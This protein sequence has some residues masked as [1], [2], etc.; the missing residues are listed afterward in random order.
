[1]RSHAI[2]S[3]AAQHFANPSAFPFSAFSIVMYVCRM[4]RFLYSL[5]IL[6]LPAAD[7]AEDDGDGGGDAEGEF[8]ACSTN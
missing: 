3:S 1:M 5:F 7:G 2:T 6:P 8:L 4:L